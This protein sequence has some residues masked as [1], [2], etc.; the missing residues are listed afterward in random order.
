MPD[1][2]PAVRLAQQ[3][4]EGL[5]DSVGLAI[6]A[7]LVVRHE[8]TGREWLALAAVLLVPQ[9]LLVRV[10]RVLA[11]RGAGRGAAAALVGAAA[12]GKAKAVLVGGTTAAAILSA[13]AG[14][15]GAPIVAPIAPH[16]IER[17]EYGTCIEAGGK[18][19]LPRVGTV[20]VLSATCF[21]AL[22]DAGASDAAGDGAP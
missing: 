21:R 7:Y 20:A 15:W 4:R 17:V 5:T 10:A 2:S 11:A 8:I 1:P 18:V 12:I 22:D 6:G 16:T 19:E 13:C 14:S 3:I 9:A